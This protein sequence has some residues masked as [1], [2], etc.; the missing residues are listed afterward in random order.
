VTSQVSEEFIEPTRQS[1]RNLL[2]LCGGGVVIGAL[3][4]FKLVPAVSS[5]IS[6]LPECQQLPW[7]YAILASALCVPSV[8]AIWAVWYARR[9]LTLKQFPPPGTWV[10]RRTRIRRGATVRWQAF[11]LIAWSIACAP[12]PVYG[13]L[14]L[15]DSGLFPLPARCASQAEPAAR[16]ASKEPS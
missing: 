10:F 14:F 8:T 4:R 11:L 16:A 1:R 15:K 12:F 9:L 5:Y 3:L 6:S 7:V 2:V 13:W